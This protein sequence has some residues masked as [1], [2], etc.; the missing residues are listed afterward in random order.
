MNQIER[1]SSLLNDLRH[2]P[3]FSKT[4]YA[5]DFITKLEKLKTEFLVVSEKAKVLARAEAPEFNVFDLLSV[6]RDEVRTHSAM[7]AELLNPRGS[8]GQ[9][10]IFL[11]AFV[12][13]CLEKDPENPA[14]QEFLVHPD[15]RKSSVLTEMHTSF[16]R[17]DIVIL[18]SVMGFVCVIENKVDAYEQGHQLKRY[19]Q[20]MKTKKMH[21]DYP[22]Q[23]LVYLTKKGSLAAT[24]GDNEYIS[25]S[26]HI[27]INNWLVSTFPKIEAPIVQGVVQQYCEIARRL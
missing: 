6:T 25:L 3:G 19:S 15:R 21:R 4:G 26:Y 11:D 7:L 1:F 13:K 22:N 16:G 9:G 10:F 2:I 17:M 5:L 20:W 27:D 18:N 8:H 14:F 12:T 23:V 24:A